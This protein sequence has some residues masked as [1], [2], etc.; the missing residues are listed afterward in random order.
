V[1]EHAVEALFDAFA[2]AY[3][4]GESP[5]VSEYLAR[6]GGERDDLGDLIDRFLRAVPAQPAT[7]E[8]I[9][10]MEARLEGEPTL[11][12]LRK[13]RRLKRETVVSALLERLGLDP[14]KRDKVARY[15]H[16]L[17]VG[18]LDPKPVSSRIWDALGELLA[19]NVR[20]LAGL[21]PRSPAPEG[22]VFHRLELHEEV[23]Y[24]ARCDTADA[25]EA[26]P[27]AAPAREGPDEI[28]RL[29]TGSA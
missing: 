26:E 25:A 20:V 12:V 15:Y 4:R 6:A 27:Q 22:A 29:F 24:L 16:E 1:N 19:A 5:D 2:Q 23:S 9:V 8:E 17:E 21:R 18:T 14:V 7:E 3:L 10:L 28:D 11:L 13:R